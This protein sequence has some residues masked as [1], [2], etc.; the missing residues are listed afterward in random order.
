MPEKH[1]T[2][3]PACVEKA[4]VMYSAHNTNGFLVEVRRLRLKG[5]R[6]YLVTT[7]TLFGSQTVQCDSTEQ[8][9]SEDV[10]W[11]VLRIVHSGKSSGHSVKSLPEGATLLK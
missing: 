1:W 9:D 10:M 6:T 3:Q 7:G 5:R 4:D 11:A 2:D 8:C